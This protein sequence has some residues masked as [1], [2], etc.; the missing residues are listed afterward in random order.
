MPSPACSVRILHVF[1]HSIPLH[2]GY[3]FRS[4]AIISA[5]R[6][7]GWTTAHLTGPKQGHTATAVESVDGLEFY[8]TPLPSASAV[9]LPLLGHVQVTNA[10]ARRLDEVVGLERPQIVHAHS[11][12]LNGLAALRVC[13]RH[14]LPLVYECRAFWEDA[15]VDHGT[16]RA[17][18]ARYRLTRA[19]ESHVFRRADAITTICEGLRKDIVARGIPAAKVTVIPNA[20]DVEHFKYQASRDSALATRI[21]L[22]DGPVLGFV[23][24]F[25]A[26]EGLDLLVAAMPAI[27]REHPDARLLL[28]GEGN[29]FASI[30]RQI[31]E[32]DL[33]NAVI[34]PGR[35]PHD[36]VS[37]YYGLIDILVYPRRAMR[38]TELVTPL[39]PLEAMAQGKLVAASDV[40][41]HR[42]LIHHGST[43]H[44]FKPGCPQALAE[45]VG[46]ML[47]HREHW[48][49]MRRSGRSFVEAERNWTRSVDRYDAVYQRLIA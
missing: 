42:E 32:L 12:A 34:T 37:A 15:A 40:G 4:R 8:R 25:Y 29:E 27:R 39:K 30:K 1:D 11:P 22:G 47:Q 13:A 20:V 7:R 26:Y 36:E 23:G 10:I 16:S 43:G 35:V 33:A 21:G 2:S 49:A 5:Q 18:G 3:T 28:V 48:D 6:A 41:G 44:L 19:I 9:R 46:H 17:G 38:L 24:S 14:E 45:C 31:G